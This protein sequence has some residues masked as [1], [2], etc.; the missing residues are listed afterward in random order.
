[1][2]NTLSVHLV[3]LGCPKNLVDSERLLG[4]ATSMGF[5]PTLDPSSADLIIVNTCAFIG[6]AAREAVAAVL[7]AAEVKKPEAHLVVVG[8][9]ASRYGRE[10]AT[11]LPE[12]S[13]V[14]VP[15]DYHGFTRAVADLFDQ[16][17]PPP[18]GPF[19]TWE[20]QPGTPPWRAWLKVA[21][22]CNHRCAYCLIPSLR[23]PLV[24]RNMDSLVKEAASLAESGVLEIT[25]VA[26]DLTAWREGDKNLADLAQ[27]I[28]Q[29]G[30]FSW[31]RLMYS[32]PERL[33]SPLVKALA[34]VPKLVPY[35]DVPLQHAS[36]EILRRMGRSGSD[37][38]ALIGRLRSWWPN[39]ALRT[40]LMV[41]FPGETEED[42]DQ[43]VRLVEEGAFDHVGVF[44]FSPEDGTEAATF[45]GQVP[46]A[47][48]ER[49]R[50]GLLARQRRISLALNRARVGTERDILVEGPSDDSEL[51]MTGRAEF[52][53]PEVDGLIY[54]D[55]QQPQSGQMV[56]ARLTKAGHYDLAATLI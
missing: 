2:S 25:L 40:T 46:Q 32:Y 35:L 48:K 23:G 33:T 16:F 31:L 20:R 53:A 55:G 34:Q 39:L 7:E 30:D 51:V 54:F 9:L 13:L 37:P 49:R 42:Y 43:V 26:Q 15:A 14:M 22:G 6:A 27:A 21:E 1:M 50:R 28:A 56:K 17:P 41:G 47:I 44:K 52:Q 11:N 29:C 38:L 3:S 12:A 10:L 45:T 4:A 19:E 8:C 18:K 24:T 36:P 5:L